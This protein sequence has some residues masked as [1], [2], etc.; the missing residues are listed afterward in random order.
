[1]LFL[2]CSEQE[3]VFDYPDCISGSG[4]LAESYGCGNIFVYQFLESTSALT[5]S[6]NSDIIDL[7]EECQTFTLGFDNPDIS[8]K[9]EIAG[10]NPDSIYFNYC[11]D[12]V[13]TN[14]GTTCIYV[15]TS[16]KLTFSLSEDNPIKKPIWDNYYFIT[17]KI[18]DLNI[19]DSNSGDYIVF[20]EIIF[21]NVGVG[22]LPG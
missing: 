7:T 5:V 18:T 15:A 22:W 20:E 6:I 12:V 17:I 10:E 9:L 19:L 2:S 21:W 11:N 3:T 14:L 16:G 13:L 8:V 4:D 1:M